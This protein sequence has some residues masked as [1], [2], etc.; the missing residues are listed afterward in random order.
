MIS[1]QN[2]NRSIEKSIGF[3]TF[4]PFFKIIIG[5][6]DQING[7]MRQ[8]TMKT[9]RKLW[10]SPVIGLHELKKTTILI[11]FIEITK[12][13]T[14]ICTKTDSIFNG[15]HCVGQKR[16]WKTFQMLLYKPFV[17]SPAWLYVAVYHRHTVACCG[18]FHRG[19]PDK[20]VAC[21]VWSVALEIHS[22][23]MKMCPRRAD[24]RWMQSHNRVVHNRKIPLD[25]SWQSPSR[26]IAYAFLA[27][28]IRYSR[29]EAEKLAKNWCEISFKFERKKNNQIEISIE[30]TGIRAC[31]VPSPTILYPCR[32]SAC[33][34]FV[35]YS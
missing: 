14:G 32:T 11:Y 15:V 8:L 25:T 24:P 31:G 20:M 23:D 34:C 28:P 4:Q 3:E 33:K 6:A 17:Y 35:M 5:N 7:I 26:E 27:T 29:W 2:K 1:H 13:R 19:M 12:K 30:P 18:S 9:E 21:N 10:L 16:V 22:I